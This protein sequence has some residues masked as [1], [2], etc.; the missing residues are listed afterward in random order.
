[1]RKH[2][3]E[4]R[5]LH[6]LAKKRMQEASE[7]TEQTEA[8]AADA[9]ADA[10]D[11]PAVAAAVVVAAA[12]VADPTN[13]NYSPLQ[14]E[15]LEVHTQDDG[16]KFAGVENDTLLVNM[17]RHR[18]RQPRLP[19]GGTGKTAD[20]GT[21]NAVVTITYE[22]DHPEDAE[23]VHYLD[24]EDSNTKATVNITVDD[25][26]VADDVNNQENSDEISLE[27]DGLVIDDSCF[28]DYVP[29]KESK[30]AS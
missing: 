21:V 30:A 29:P 23:T 19:R 28:D 1:M 8:V 26:T 6:K 24:L 13:L 14:R 16:K 5:G 9:A 7:T 3:P 10:A 15:V 25:V 4:V 2:H 20:G 27:S 22:D 12:A 18:T 17:H 11:V